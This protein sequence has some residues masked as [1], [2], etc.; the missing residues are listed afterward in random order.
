MDR[1]SQERNVDEPF[2]AFSMTRRESNTLM[3]SSE[4]RTSSSYNQSTSSS[5][6]VNGGHDEPLMVATP[7]DS[8]AS[9]ATFTT[10][11]TTSK[12]FLQDRTPVRG[13]QDII[14]RMRATD[15]GILLRF[16][17]FL[18]HWPFHFLFQVLEIE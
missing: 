11:A 13:M 4:R 18:V 2:S 16:F 17:P 8:L 14:G 3:S 12:S 7:A 5:L 6:V 1:Q 10:T 9:S 15:A